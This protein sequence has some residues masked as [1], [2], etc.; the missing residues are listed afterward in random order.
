MSHDWI[1]RPT[2]NNLSYFTAQM[3]AFVAI[4]VAFC[5]PFRTIKSRKRQ[6]ARAQSE[7]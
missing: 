4:N 5:C 7:G 1:D 2:P 6:Q 3:G